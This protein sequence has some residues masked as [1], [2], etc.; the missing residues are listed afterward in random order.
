ELFEAQAIAQARA[1]IEDDATLFPGFR[2][3]AMELPFGGDDSPFEFGGARIRGRMDRVDE[4]PGGVLVTD[5]KSGS[6]ISGAEQFE[7]DRLFQP[8]IYAAAASHV[9]GR[10]CLGG[11][12][13]SLSTHDVRGFYLAGTVDTCGHGNAKD[14]LDDEAFS[15]LVE[16]TEQRVRAVVHQMST[17][18]VSPTPGRT[19][20][21]CL[22]QPFCEVAR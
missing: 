11:I 18:D 4:G 20:E 6:T 22:A 15:T 12:Y 19:C 5:Y 17:G 14:G 1:I 21:Y 2:P 16:S 8:V 7:K 3:I 13:R 10:P 9:L